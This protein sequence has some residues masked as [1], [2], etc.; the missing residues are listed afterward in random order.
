MLVSNSVV[1]SGQ[2]LLIVLKIDRF[3]KCGF[4]QIGPSK[5]GKYSM[6]TKNFYKTIAPRPTLCVSTINK[7][8]ISNLAPY[9]FA[10][11]LKIEPPIIGIV[12]GGEKDTLLNARETRDF[13]VAPLTGNW[14]GKGVRTEVEL[15]RD[16][17]EFEEVGLTEAESKKVEA[18]SVKEAPINLEC[19]YR[20]ELRIADSFLLLGDV[21]HVTAKRG[22]LKDDR[23]NLEE[24]G[25]VGHVCEEDFC[26]VDEI[27]RIER[28]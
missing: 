2:F 18:P 13:V 20:D 28:E 8:G 26:V 17:S 7:N 11:P 5:G 6:E 9:S 19:S 22:A 23:V 3:S 10:T 16:K 12:V 27:T 4:N 14:K 1:I 15:P 25:T 21:V 24:L